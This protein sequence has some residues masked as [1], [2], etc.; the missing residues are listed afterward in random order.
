[1]VIKMSNSL[2]QLLERNQ[3]FSKGEGVI[4]ISELKEAREQTIEGQK[5]QTLIIACSDSRV[6]PET[7]FLAK[8]GEIFTLRTAGNVVDNY[9]TLATI[10]YAI[11]HLNVKTVLVI[12]HENCGAVT[13]ALKGGNNLEENLKKLIEKIKVSVQQAKEKLERA[14]ELYDE[15]RLLEESIK[16]N[17]FN[18]INTILQIKGVKEKIEKGD[19]KIIPAY[20]ELSTGVVRILE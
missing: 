17:I 16:F 18:T 13:A 14:K 1:M 11:F 4:S 10:E 15:N 9:E 19:L 12:G 3:R 7:I 20:Y 8:P 6:A 5:P 2:D